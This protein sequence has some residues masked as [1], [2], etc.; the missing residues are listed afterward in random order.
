M[1]DFV[2]HLDS[3]E[4]MWAELDAVNYA[5]TQGGSIAA[6]DALTGEIDETR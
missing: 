5:L 4:S 2:R 6:W 3:G 1:Y